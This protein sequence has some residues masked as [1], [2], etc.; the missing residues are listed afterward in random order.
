MTRAL[1]GYLTRVTTTLRLPRMCLVFA[2]VA[3]G[4]PLMCP[5]S[6]FGQNRAEVP[7]HTE[8]PVF[9]ELF[10][11]SYSDS[12]NLDLFHK[13]KV[14]LIPLG[15]EAIDGF[16]WRNHK[17]RDLS[18]WM[19]IEDFKYLL[20]AINSGRGADARFVRDWFNHWYEIHEQDPQPNPGAQQPMTVG[21]R[22]MVL[23]RLLRAVEALEER[24][25]QIE[26]RLRE[27]ITEHRHFLELDEN[28]ESRSN[29]GLW[30]AMGLFETARVDHDTGTAG[31][32]LRRMADV[33]EASVSEQ[34]IHRE[35][36]AG[37]HF[38]V[39]RWLSEFV[40]YFASLGIDAWG[41]VEI[42]ADASGK[43]CGVSYYLFDHMGNIPQI[44]DTDAR[45]VDPDSLSSAAEDRDPV[46]YDED[47]GL[48]VYKDPPP[49]GL[50]R[51]L[52]FVTRQLSKL[53]LSL[54]HTHR[55]M[56]SVYFS[57]N[58]E[59]ILGDGGRYEYG[60]SVSRRFFVSSA[61]H[62]TIVPID[63]LDSTERIIGP[64]GGLPPRYSEQDGSVVFEGFM[65]SQ[66][67]Y[68][69]LTIPRDKSEFVVDD[70]ISP[71]FDVVVLWNMGRDVVDISPQSI[72]E[73]DGREVHWWVVTTGKGRTFRL[74]VTLP[75]AVGGNEATI[76]MAKGAKYPMLG[77]Y[78]PGYREMV[79]VTVLKITVRTP[80]GA[81]V[82]TKVTEQ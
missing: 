76:A 4:M 72:G 23:V 79:P 82:R 61:A 5:P 62:N 3:A 47:G 11:A 24:D 69:R 60:N 63:K 80:G 31:Y 41:D 67:V 37:Y 8:A 66:L 49:S 74:E 73:D 48:A 13:N 44:G 28:F 75:P 53:T 30:E 22:A 32:A 36:A 17:R 57:C 29:H 20:P 16:D 64:I 81:I 58:G 14:R 45:R 9:F 12:A 1:R 42:L 50:G 7:A 40:Q 43:M 55:D 34:G 65:N 77:W 70:A 21:I 2:V 25:T 71:E 38:H 19:R 46:L 56:L 35:H 27:T 15:I 18:W 52:I 33:V 26:E 78:S 10:A 39:S 6:L 59:V 68:R 54:A 51:Y